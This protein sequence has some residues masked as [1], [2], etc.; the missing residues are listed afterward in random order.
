MTERRVVRSPLRVFAGWLALITTLVVVGTASPQPPA[1]SAEEEKGRELFRAGK[2]DEAIEEFKKAAKANPNLPPPRVMVAELFYQAGQ[3]PQARAA[4][5]QAAVEDPDHPAVLLLNGSFAFG[6]GRLTDTILS[7]QAALK[8]AES[9]R[10]NADQRK[11]F[12]RDARNGLALSLEARR[13]HAAAKEHLVAL[14]ASEPKNAVFRS[15]LAAALFRIGQVDEAF[16]EFQT[17]HRDDPTIDPPELFM[18]RLW[19]S[20]PD[21]AKAEEWFKKATA[22]HPKNARV[23]RE[24]AGWLL[25]QGRLADARPQIETA[26]SLEPAAR[27]TA[28]L[29]GL[30]ARHARDYAA[31]ETIFEK[32]HRDSPADR[33]A[34]ANLAL[35][36]AE[37][38]DTTKQRRAVELAEN[39]VRQ[40]QRQADGY[41]VLGWCYYRAGRLD[42][43]F[44]ALSTAAS[45]GTVERD[46]A[47]YL[48]KVLADK[49]RPDDARKLLQDALTAPGA[50]VNKANAEAFLADLNKKFPPKSDEKP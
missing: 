42:D 37:S 26:A 43:A 47:Y 32:M 46:T 36:L 14:V 3:G 29:R 5:E 13:D 50:F 11:K 41:A 27:D 38:A 6:D 17:A 21:P 22:A 16:A 24:H 25:N 39:L 48:A 4:L 49:N 1:V 40:D 45:S 23:T 15:R 44:K 31:A 28:A 12:Q 8:A 7:L 10:W 2:I 30:M 34:A 35:V 9:P 20:R 18:A 19:A 33:F